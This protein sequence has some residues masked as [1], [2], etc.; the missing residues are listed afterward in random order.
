MKINTTTM[1]EGQSADHAA[2]NRVDISVKRS[3]YSTRCRGDHKRSV[4]VQ[5][6]MTCKREEHLLLKTLSFLC[7]HSSQIRAIFA[8]LI[9]SL[10]LGSTSLSYLP[11]IFTTLRGGHMNRCLHLNIG[12]RIYFSQNIS[13]ST[14]RFLLS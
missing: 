12:S 5:R 3:R 8:T 4:H 6:Y 9:T 2:F 14:R 7:S 11:K 1:K 13:P 10:N